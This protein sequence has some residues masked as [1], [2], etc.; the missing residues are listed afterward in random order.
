MRDHVIIFE[1]MFGICS[2]DVGFNAAK[3]GRKN[4]VQDA[5]KIL[6][7]ELEKKSVNRKKKNIV[8]KDTDFRTI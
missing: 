2:L 3:H 4:G 6:F 8:L 5:L 7:V 1:I